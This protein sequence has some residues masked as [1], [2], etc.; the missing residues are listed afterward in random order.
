MGMTGGT[1]TP[2]QLKCI[3]A[4]GR[5]GCMDS[6]ELHGVVYTAAKKEHVSEL[7]VEEAR[8]V[9]DRLKL[10]TGEKPKRAAD[11]ATKGQVQLIYSLAERLGWSEEPKRLTAFL[12][13]QYGISHPS[14]LDRRST[15]SCIA[16]TDSLTIEM[17]PEQYQPLAEILGVQPLLKLAEQYGGA[18]LYIPKVEA[19]VKALRDKRIQKE[20]NGYN[21]KELAQK[22]EL[23]VNWVLNICKDNPL[24]EQQSLF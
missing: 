18:S 16:A 23:S 9:I 22:Y 3:Y 1:L 20:Y 15:N 8:R 19:L 17:L 5:A 6:E 21:A 12:E 24:P 7:T 11:R 14:F 4:L 2:K 13:K 10:L